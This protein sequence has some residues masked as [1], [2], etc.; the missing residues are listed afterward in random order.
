MSC[1][2]N[3]R[4]KMTALSE[5]ADLLH[6]MD[7]IDIHRTSDGGKNRLL[8]FVSGNPFIDN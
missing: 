1:D 7:C 3:E 8:N 4:R 6:N 5:E 2:D